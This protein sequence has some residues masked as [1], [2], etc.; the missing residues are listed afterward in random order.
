[1]TLKFFLFLSML[2]FFLLSLSLSFLSLFSSIYLFLYL[3]SLLCFIF[4][5]SLY[6]ID[7]THAYLVWNSFQ[8]CLLY[9]L[10]MTIIRGRESRLNIVVLV[11]PRVVVDII[12][13]FSFKKITL[14]KTPSDQTVRGDA[15]FGNVHHFLSHCSQLL[16]SHC[17]II[18][19]SNVNCPCLTMYKN[20]RHCLLLM[21]ETESF[22]F[23]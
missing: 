10:M 18:F 6:W 7:I 16:F 1:M 8:A 23:F 22:K 15:V 2:P 5:L 17:L 4:S 13:I 19:D 11:W 21:P 3:L 20:G 12:R 14:S 9:Y